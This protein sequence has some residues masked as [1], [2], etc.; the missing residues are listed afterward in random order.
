M[1]IGFLGPKGTFSFEAASIYS[2]REDNLIEYKTIKDCILALKESNI[3]KVIVP[4]ENSLHGDVLETIDSLIEVDGVFI[5]KELII[6][7]NQNLISNELYSFEQIKK[8][9][10]HP[11]ALAQCR[12]F[13]ETNLKNAEII[14]V[15]ST[16]LAAKEIRNKEHAACISSKACIE[17]YD[18][19]LIKE[20]IQDNDYNQ[21]KF[22]VL[23]NNENKSGDKM[24][25]I[26]STNNEPGAL[27]KI[28]GIFY[29]N[30]INLSKI[31]SRPAKTVL[32][33]YVFLVDLDV[34]SKLEKALKLI[35]EKCRYFKILGR[36]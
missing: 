25:I 34:N 23:S 15:S 9:Y 32:G 5:E 28:L 29:D 24:S 19:K 17:E 16:A 10:S 30:G 22:W 18:L 11:Q 2:A 20:N 3:D 14:E 26:F 7:I 13:I 31:E 1:N 21:T 8:I 6:K 33:E 4:V 27:Y 12:N 35:R 36:Y